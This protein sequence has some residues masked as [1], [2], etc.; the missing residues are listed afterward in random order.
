LITNPPRPFGATFEYD[1][2]S[3][4]RSQILLGDARISFQQRGQNEA[5][6]GGVRWW[7]REGAGVKIKTQEGKAPRLSI[8]L[9]APWTSENIVRRVPE[10]STLV[11]LIAGLAGLA[12]SYRVRRKS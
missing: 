8:V 10:P 6:V 11:L 5:V 12:G 4:V 2:T 7:Q 9:D 3:Y 1:V